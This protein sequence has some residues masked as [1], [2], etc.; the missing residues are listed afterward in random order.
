MGSSGFHL[1]SRGQEFGYLG[2]MQR[3]Y[4]YSSDLQEVEGS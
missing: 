2:S 3:E 4:P 1:D